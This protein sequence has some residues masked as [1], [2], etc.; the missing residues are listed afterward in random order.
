MYNNTLEEL[1]NRPIIQQLYTFNISDLG[2]L[3]VV[4]LVLHHTASS[5]NTGTLSYVFVNLVCLLF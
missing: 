2:E 3:A 1:P 4:R 5:P